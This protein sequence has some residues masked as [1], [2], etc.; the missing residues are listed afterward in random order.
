[1]ISPELLRRYP[2]F[3]KLTEDQLR[4]LAMIAEE[5]ELGDGEAAFQE[6]ETAQALFFLLY[7]CIDLYYTVTEA[8]KAKDR[9]EINVG[10]P[11][12]ISTL[13]EPHVLTATARSCGSSR[14]LRFNGEELQ[15]VLQADPQL[16]LALLRKMAGAAIE[17]L[18]AARVQLAAAW[19]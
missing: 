5:V 3:N 4:E 14:V 1:M 13:I 7:G 10:E 16:E 11:F 15:Q 19:V 12:G 17:R 8:Y 2:F 6:G 9:K 18:H